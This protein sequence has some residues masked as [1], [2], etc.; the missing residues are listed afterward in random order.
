MIIANIK[1]YGDK[2]LLAGLKKLAITSM[3]G[4]NRAV[5][6]TCM[7]IEKDA[8]TKAPVDT[9][10]LKSSI[11][12]KVDQ[13]GAHSISGQVGTNVFYAIYQ[14][15]GTTRMKAHPYLLPAFYE[16]KGFFVRQIENELKKLSLQ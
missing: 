3:A 7:S 12:H 14:E 4:L 8:K 13:T 1:M 16:N 15:F 9:G 10:R 11:T 2:E 6:S 5:T